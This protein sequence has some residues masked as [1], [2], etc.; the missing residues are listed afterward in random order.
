[1]PKYCSLLVAM[2]TAFCNC[3]RAFETERG[4][5]MKNH[6]ASP[7]MIRIDLEMLNVGEPGTINNSFWPNYRVSKKHNSPHNCLLF[8]IHAIV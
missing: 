2:V 3:F 1:M 4:T 8:T 5:V 6:V 7:K